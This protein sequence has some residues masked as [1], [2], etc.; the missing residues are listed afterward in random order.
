MVIAR[1]GR[2]G[3]AAL[4]LRGHEFFTVGLALTAR[5]RCDTSLERPLSP[6]R[7]AGLSPGKTRQPQTDTRETET[8]QKRDE[9][10]TDEGIGQ[11]I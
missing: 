8:G 5:R 7:L 6:R 3:V 1:L 4:I 11:V 2:T 10:G 9:T